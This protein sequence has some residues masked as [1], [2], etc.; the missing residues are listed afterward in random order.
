M[1]IRLKTAQN[2]VV[3]YEAQFR[4]VFQ[5]VQDEKDARVYLQSLAGRL[6]D[7][8]ESIRSGNSLMTS[9]SGHA[10]DRGWS[11][12]RLNKSQRMEL[13]EIQRSL[14]L[15]ISSKQKIAD[16][17]TKV[18]AAYLATQSQLRDAEN[19]IAMQNRD[20]E[21]KSAELTTYRS[22]VDLPD[23][24]APGIPLL[25]QFL[26]DTG[27][28]RPESWI[29]GTSGDYEMSNSALVELRGS[30]R[31][32]AAAGQHRPEPQ[33]YENLGDP[34]A[35]SL[36][37]SGRFA[38]ST[39]GGITGSPKAITVGMTMPTKAKPHRFVTKTFLGPVKC[40][41]CTSLLVGI[42]RQG[43]VC[44]D[45]QF[46]CH[47]GCVPKVAPICPPPP[48][49]IKRPVGIDPT[50]GIGTAYEGYVRIPK[51]G[52]VRKGW[53]RQYVVVCDFKLFLYDLMNGSGNGTFNEN[54]PPQA[55][56]NASII[57]DMRDEEFSVATVAESD[58]IHANKKD[59]GTSFH[60]ILV[61]FFFFSFFC[62]GGFQFEF[63][64]FGI[65]LALL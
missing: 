9:P 25:T 16:E 36:P 60:L 49:Q 48:D 18:R 30:Q 54:R 33:S 3:Q 21:A 11:S 28:Y 26:K 58:V 46:A 64:S 56:P 61:F 2:Q 55:M 44:E 7:D 15:E 10:P 62:F 57:I 42:T 47:V 27:T 8:V 23:A 52:G 4:D 50:Q 40:N 35:R 51:P 29:S 1:E 31:G 63:I 17:L 32:G 39:S 19:R 24:R 14:Q 12:R 22:A 37:P 41:Y 65:L 13:Q 38:T 6:N 45:C 20:L 43:V 5:W 53:M 59:L 34:R